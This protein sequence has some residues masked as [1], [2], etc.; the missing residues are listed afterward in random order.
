[1]HRHGP[2]IPVAT[3]LIELKTI[4]SETCQF[5]TISFA[6]HNFVSDLFMSIKCPL[7]QLNHPSEF[8][9]RIKKALSFI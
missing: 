8:R 3:F 5:L 6:M 4:Y 7:F 9:T 1:M 2:T